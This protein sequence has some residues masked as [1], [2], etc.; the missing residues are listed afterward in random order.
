MNP[1]Y[2]SSF[3][4]SFFCLD[5]LFI[6]IFSSLTLSISLCAKMLDQN[7]FAEPN[8]H[9][10]TFLHPILMCKVTYWVHERAVGCSHPCI[11]ICNPPP[12][13]NHTH[14]H[15]HTYPYPP[16][17]LHIWSIWGALTFHLFF[18]FFLYIIPPPFWIRLSNFF[19]FLWY[20]KLC[21]Y[22]LWSWAVS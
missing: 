3:L 16:T 6:I 7:H 15:T 19:S 22:N 14:T 8:Q 21:M 9:V 17:I 10:L 11:Q 18:L 1:F 13:K 20:D 4:P 5:C 2:L 12:K